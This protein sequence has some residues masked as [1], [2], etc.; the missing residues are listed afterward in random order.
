M[1]E[2]QIQF[3][4]GSV[5]KA[6]KEAGAGSS[7]LWKVPRSNIQVAKDFNV[8][9]RNDKYAAR[10]RE[11]ADSIKEN[12]FYPDKP[13]AGYVA[14]DD[15]GQQVIIVTDGH[16]RLDAVDLAISEGAEI[17][18]LPVVTK[19]HGTSME[20]LTIALHV[21]NNG[22]P[23]TPFE[24]AL[25][26]KR[27]AGYGMEIATI[28]KKM[29]FTETYLDGLMTLMAAP[30]EV[31]KLVEV[32]KVSASLAIDM[33]KKHGPKA[34]EM[35]KAGLA[36]AEASGKTRMT[37]KHINATPR[38]AKPVLVRSI[39][40][41]RQEKLDDD[42]RFLKFLA[43]LGGMKTADELKGFIAAEQEKAQKKAAKAEKASKKDAQ[44]S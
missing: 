34:L 19:P 16:T 3:F 10:V 21:G 11:I 22:N 31:R 44:P 27:L 4:P 30:S 28:A 1:S 36:K 24:Q 35:L 33:L 14:L 17:E 42:E 23:L 13:L 5:K 41:L 9:V 2:Q 12:G 7:D 37:P 8:R 38:V 43:F 20:D 40:Y 32:D 15:G 26:C 29:G 6:M 18:L 39:D 25:V